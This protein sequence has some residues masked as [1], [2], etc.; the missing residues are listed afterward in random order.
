M[1]GGVYNFTRSTNPIGV[2]RL[3]SCNEHFVLWGTSTSSFFMTT[4]CDTGVYGYADR[5][6]MVVLI[7][8]P[9]G[10]YCMVLYNNPITNAACATQRRQS[11]VVVYIIINRPTVWAA[12]GTWTVEWPAYLSGN[13]HDCLLVEWPVY[14]LPDGYP[15]RLSSPL[16]G[17]LNRRE[18]DTSWSRGFIAKVSASR[19]I[20]KDVS[21]MT[22]FHCRGY[23]CTSPGAAL[24]CLVAEDVSWVAE[25]AGYPMTTLIQ[26]SIT[27]PFWIHFTFKNLLKIVSKAKTIIYTKTS[28]LGDRPEVLIN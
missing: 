2:T 6:E 27:T 5:C 21:S 1:C 12:T 8:H 16:F 3:G 19:C 20:K 22:K 25:T 7:H 4:S 14:L 28:P 13:C 15:Q 18:E 26:Y 17:A 9:C 24:R 10:I 23:H 11:C